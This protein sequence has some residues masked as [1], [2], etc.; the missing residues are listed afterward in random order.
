MQE[1]IT[2]PGQNLETL[3]KASASHDTDLTGLKERMTN[4]ETVLGEYEQ[5][6]TTLQETVSSMQQSITSILSRLDALEQ[7][8]SGSEG[9]GTE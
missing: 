9:G 4:A 3:S 8:N 1:S 5:I 2:A 6:L 7:S